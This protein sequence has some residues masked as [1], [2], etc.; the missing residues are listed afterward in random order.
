MKLKSF[1]LLVCFLYASLLLAGSGN[2][3]PA[4]PNSFGIKGLLNFSIN[5]RS[6][7][8]QIDLDRLERELKGAND[9]ICDATDGQIVFGKV[10]VTAGSTNESLADMWILPQIGR[11]FADP[12]GLTRDGLRITQYS[13]AIN[14]GTIAHEIGHY[15]FDLYDEYNEQCRFDTPCG[16]GRCLAASILDGQNNSIMQAINATEFCVPANHDLLRGDGSGCPSDANCPI[17]GICTDG[18]FCAGYNS[19]T[20]AY[21]ATQHTMVRGESTWETLVKNIDDNYGIELTMPTGLPVAA[22]PANC[23]A[24]LDIDIQVGGTDLVVLAID[25][26]GSMETEDAG[27][28]TRLAF[29]QA[30][31]RVFGDLQFNNNITVAIISFNDNSE[32]V[33]DIEVLNIGN[34]ADFK[35]DIDG[36][37]ARGNTAIGDGLFDSYTEIIK[38]KLLTEADG[39]VVSNPTIFLISD[40]QNNRGSDPKEI[41]RL[42]TEAGITLH[43]ISAGDGS[44]TSLLSDLASSTGGSMLP[45][46]ADDLIPP[47]Y[48]ELSAKHQ[49]MS[50]ISI[51]NIKN[52][53]IKNPDA[54]SSDEIPVSI[55]EFLVEE[56]ATELVLYRSLKSNQQFSDPSKGVFNHVGYFTAPD[57]SISIPNTSIIKD[58]SNLYEIVK[59]PNPSSG[60]WTYV[61]ERTTENKSKFHFRGF[62]NNAK[63]DYYIDAFPPVINTLDTF[64]N[65]SA[66]TSFDVPLSDTTIT[67]EGYVIRPDSSRVSINF[68]LDPITR[69]VSSDFNAFNGRGLYTVRSQVVVPSNADYTSGEVIFDGPPHPDTPVTAFGRS[70][71]TSFF[72]DL[73]GCPACDN[74]DCDGDG[75]PNV[76]EDM[77]EDIDGDGLPNRCDEDSDGDDI[78][79]NKEKLDDLDSNGRPDAYDPKFSQNNCD[80]ELNIT[81]IQTPSCGESDGFIEVEVSGGTGSLIYTWGHDIYLNSNKAID[82]GETNYFVNVTDEAGCSISQSIEFEIVCEGAIKGMIDGPKNIPEGCSFPMIVKVD[83]REAISPD[84]VLGSFTAAINWDTD[85]LQ[86]ADSSALLSNFNGIINIDQENGKIIF[87]GVNPTGK[88]GLIPIFVVYFQAIGAVRDSTLV[89]LDISN[90]STTLTFKDILP[91]LQVEEGKITITQN[92][93][94]GDVN[95]DGNTDVTD[96]LILLTYDAELGV[97]ESIQSNIEN[98]IGDVNNDGSTDATDALLLL[99]YDAMLPIP[100][101]IETSRCPS[102]NELR[103]QYL[104]QSRFSKNVNVWW[105]A[106][107]INQTLQVPVFAD[108]ETLEQALGSYKM[109]IEWNPKALKL[110]SFQEGLESNFANPIVNDNDL[111]SGKLT[112]TNA[113]V[114]GG[115]GLVMLANLTF[116]HIGKNLE[117]NFSIKLTSLSTSETFIPLKAIIQEKKKA[118]DLLSDLIISP[119]PFHENLNIQYSLSK[120]MAIEID[121]YNTIGQ[122]IKQLAKGMQEKGDHT[123]SWHPSEQ[124]IFD[125]G[126]YYIRAKLGNKIVVRKVLFTHSK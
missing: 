58:P 1:I 55:I 110:R 74:K 14:S 6:P 78:P 31:G 40:G 46:L 57:G 43:T 115:Q 97:P 117:D 94:I 70:A 12:N 41:A 22:Q 15:A 8:S 28:M 86:Y 67:Y 30:A 126:V 69:T 35:N 93:L 109:T 66:Q 34:L 44:N 113:N 25:N 111:A 124:S 95:N 89:G 64:I 96:A 54:A 9:I 90:L 118:E 50:M 65:I 88:V 39:G 26:S 59:I 38:A 16:I 51:G 45:A 62:I 105:E 122:P 20:N 91:A 53:F 52:T 23:D 17:Q 32:V 82:L 13:N 125:A 73:P 63:P 120:K 75:I 33:R 4:P 101:P 77:Y 71:T 29:A 61:A 48:A 60:V 85:K 3:T 123:I 2:I 114:E 18:D 102:E 106:E 92:G 5:F 47:T 68:K 21:E 7:P 119:N 42:L 10:T 76:E 19:T 83:M 104:S 11:S 87:N 24:F 72:V 99:T 36:I 116:D 56:D 108:M 84:T 100:Y 80:L 79:D 107:E 37:Q 49:G 121:I 98:G 112:L 103:E 81:A 27:D